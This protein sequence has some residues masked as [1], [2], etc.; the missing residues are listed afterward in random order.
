M[1]GADIRECFGCGRQIERAHKVYKQEHYCGTC[2]AREFKPKPCPQCGEL[3]RLPARHPD[4]ICSNCQKRQPCVRCGKVNYLIGLLS[5]YG[6][7]CNACARYFSE[8]KPCSRCG[9][10]SHHLSRVT[11]LGFD[12]PVCPRCARADHGCC[13]ACGRSRRLRVAPDGKRLCSKCLEHGTITC[14]KCGK[15]M[16]AGRGDCCADC[17]WRQVYEQR[18][19]F[20]LDALNSS[21][22]PHYQAFAGWL[23]ER[24]GAHKASRYLDRYLTFFQMLE[25]AWL[26][27]TTSY[28]PLVK[29]FGAEVLRRYQLAALWLKESREWTDDEATR[30]NDSEQRSINRLLQGISNPQA[31]EVLVGY[32]E[33]LQ[34]KFM[35]EEM[36]LRSVRLALT[37]AKKLLVQTLTSKRSIPEQQDVAAYLSHSP[38]QK[39]ALHGFI[40]YL[41]RSQN[42]Q[43]S[44]ALAQKTKHKSQA[45]AALEMRLTQMVQ[46][47]ETDRR[48]QERWAI[49]ALSYFHGLTGPA[50]RQ[51]I[52]NEGLEDDGDGLLFRHQ[53]LTYWI[54]K[55]SMQL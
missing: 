25:R 9:V 42:S 14:P 19:R 30:L 38:G 53:G 32:Y 54:P 17:Y 12:E 24:S 15:P 51:L 31:C 43:L 41:N 6:P 22:Q 27:E 16:P 3:A 47:P 33:Y 2:Y 52:A 55:C 39:A 26:I 20:N 8:P 28:Q 13:Q 35:R 23:F 50:I 21:I 46:K 7:V 29:E 49:T 10:M 40:A 44:M 11:R 48:F 4:A 36:S 18:L 5:E 1:T 37:P 45:K 34:S